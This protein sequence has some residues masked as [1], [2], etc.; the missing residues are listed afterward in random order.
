MPRRYVKFDLLVG[1]RYIDILFPESAWSHVKKAGKV[2]LAYPSSSTMAVISDDEDPEKAK[3]EKNAIG[4]FVPA[5]LLSS[6]ER[7]ATP[8][9]AFP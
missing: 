2:R 6:L 3:N 8:R 5:T 9:T 4:V 7:T 1:K